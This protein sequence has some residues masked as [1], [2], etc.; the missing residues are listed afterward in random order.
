VPDLARYGVRYVVVHDSAP[1]L[2]YIPK[3]GARV[4][5]LTY[6]GGSREAALYRVTAPASKFTTYARTGFN[7]PEGE[8]PG[9]VRWLSENGGTLEV[10]GDCDDCEGV[11]TFYSGAFARERTLTI[12]DAQGGLV[13]E[14]TIGGTARKIRLPLSFSRRA[15]LSFA[16]DPPPDQVNEFVPGDDT[17]SFGVFIAR[18][19]FRPS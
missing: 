2:A 5:G 3:P 10:L 1:R 16:T 12:R 19:R 17:R 18:V 8:P 9:V 6:I 11:L 4:P 13:F 15:T 7:A 14:G